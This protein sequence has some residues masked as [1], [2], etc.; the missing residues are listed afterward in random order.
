MSDPKSDA[1]SDPWRTEFS[2]QPFVYRRKK[3]TAEPV[4][5]A[6]GREQA[7]RLGERLA[8]RN[9]GVLVYSRRVAPALDE[10][11]EPEVLAAH[12]EL[13]RGICEQLAVPRR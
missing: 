12:G 2:V 13:P 11:D 10:Y 4:R 1:K 5:P 3:L 6:G 8:A 9:A 7:M